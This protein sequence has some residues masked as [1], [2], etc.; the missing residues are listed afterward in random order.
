MV[1]SENRRKIG[2]LL[3]VVVPLIT[4]AITPWASYDPINLPKFAF[5]V[6]AAAIVMSV[7]VL[8]FRFLLNS[9][10]RALVIVSAV[11]AFDLILVLLVSASPFNQQFFGT[12]GRNTG[13]LTYLALLIFFLATAISFGDDFG[14]KLLFS[15][16]GT[17]ALSGL[18]GLMQSAKLDPFTWNNPYSPVLGFLG[19]PDFE[20]SFMGIC[21]VAAVAFLMKN[22]RARLTRGALVLYVLVVLYVIGK[23]NAQ[24]GF[25]VFVIGCAAIFYLFILKSAR[26][27]KLSIPYLLLGILGGVLVVLGSLNKGPLAHFL[28]KVSVTYRADYWRA[29]WKMTLQHPLFG[30]G[31]DSYG[32]WYRSTRSLIATLR[33]GPDTV[34]NAAHNVLLDFSAN[35]GFPLL[36]AYLFI[37]AL[38]LMAAIRVI[39]RT[40]EFDATHAGLFSTWIAYQ[41][42]S[43]I[44]LNQIGLA[45][46]GWV[47]SGALVGYEIYTRG[48]GQAKNAGKPKA[49]VKTRRKQKV[50]G[51]S[52]A[53]TVA[54]FVGLLI[55]LGL[56]LPPFLADTKFRLALELGNPTLIQKSVTQ[57]PIDDI[58]L[59]QGSGVL[60]NGKLEPEALALAKLGA[61]RDPRS[62]YAWQGIYSS[63]LATAAE[64]TE[65]LRRMR[66][67][68]PHNPTLK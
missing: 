50:E 2:S 55:G 18:Y 13:F 47:L 1:V 10:Y 46:W 15:L 35:G 31:L 66:I 16:L 6:T 42:Q 30:V 61:K 57:W 41:I 26:F 39:R 59:M 4:F 53:T 25:L 48:I 32:D 9:Q 24:Q 20:S 29:G 7:L 38:S 51:G 14:T 5:L 37:V 60:K 36:F 43:F 11:F 65:A 49:N 28:Y 52:P 8:D 45:I 34:S 22:G 56:G 3:L 21:G 64:R 17:G 40:S 44:S 58:R 54:I 67:L 27:K 63:T 68:D 23:T 12:S 33:R 19:N 62:F